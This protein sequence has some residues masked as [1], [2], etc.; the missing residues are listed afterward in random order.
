VNTLCNLVENFKPGEAYNIGGNRNHT[1]EELS[2][3]I[4]KVTG[5]DPGLVQYRDPEILTTKAKLVDV[6]KAVRDLGHRDTYSLEEGLRLTAEWM[7]RVYP[8]HAG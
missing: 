8:R 2:D 5:A 4:L 6:S 1:I 7:R 3:V